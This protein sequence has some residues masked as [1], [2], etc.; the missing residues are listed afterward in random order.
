MKLRR[1]IL[2]PLGRAVPGVGLAILLAF[3][4]FVATGALHDVRLPPVTAAWVSALLVLAWFLTRLP[5]RHR[6]AG[7]PP[8]RDAQTELAFELHHGRGVTGWR[9]RA[10]TRARAWHGRSPDGP[11]PRFD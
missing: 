4:A 3:G 8:A 5:L 7:R 6:W 1:R 9:E 11:R 2:L 10:R